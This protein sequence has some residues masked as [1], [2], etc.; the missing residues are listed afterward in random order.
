MDRSALTAVRRQPRSRCPSC[1]PA[2][3]VRPALLTPGGQDRPAQQQSPDERPIEQ[4]RGTP[5]SGRRNGPSPPRQ[6]RGLPAMARPGSFSRRRF[7]RCFFPDRPGPWFP[8]RPGRGGVVP[9]VDYGTRRGATA[10]TCSFHGDSVTSSQTISCAGRVPL[11]TA[12]G[13]AAPTDDQP[14]LHGDCLGWCLVSCSLPLRELQRLYC[15]A[16]VLRVARLRV[17]Q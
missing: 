15:L 17:A 11:D 3:A 4:A 6:T 1:S 12:R 2:R 10:S 13:V 8:V 16:I 9:E 7:R 5:T 14:L